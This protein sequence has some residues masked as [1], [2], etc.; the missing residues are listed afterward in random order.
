MVSV[1][2]LWLYRYPIGA[3]TVSGFDKMPVSAFFSIL[4]KGTLK[5]TL[6]GILEVDLYVACLRESE[7]NVDIDISVCKRHRISDGIGYCAA[8]VCAARRIFYR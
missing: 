5:E 4:P 7:L 3:V 8:A 6:V 1:V 2:P